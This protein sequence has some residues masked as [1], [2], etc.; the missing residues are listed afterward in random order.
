MKQFNDQLPVGL[1]ACLARGLCTGGYTDLQES[2]FKSRPTLIFLGFS[3]LQEFHYLGVMIFFTFTFF[4]VLHGID[5]VSS[6]SSRHVHKQSDNFLVT[7][8]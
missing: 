4:C 5:I 2:G 7:A 3:Q 6:P 8:V 1:L